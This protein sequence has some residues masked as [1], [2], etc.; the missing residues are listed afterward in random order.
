M[1]QPAIIPEQ[2]QYPTDLPCDDGIPLETPI[3]RENMNILIDLAIEVMKP[4]KDIFAGGN[5]FLYY[6]LEEQ[7]NKDLRGPDFF[8]V[9]G[10]D[11]ERERETWTL[12]EEKWKFPNI[13]I[14]LLSKSTYEI[15]LKDKKELYEQ[16]FHTEEYF[17]YDPKEPDYLRGWRL[18]EYGFYIELK[19]NEDGWLWSKELNCWL[20]VWTGEFNGKIKTYLRMYNKQKELIFLEAEKEKQK[21]KLLLDKLRELG[22]NPNTIE[23]D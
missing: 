22:I 3:H 2:K 20:G 11:G 21:N 1:K 10:V 14:E 17:V 5:M 15:D 9:K 18:N 7:K 6:N 4:R 8:L 16:T 23:Y 19:K 12:W 13:I